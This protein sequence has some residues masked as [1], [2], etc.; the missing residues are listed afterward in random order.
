MQTPATESTHF[1]PVMELLISRDPAELLRFVGCSV[2][3][4]QYRV[5]TDIFNLSGKQPVSRIDS[6][7][8]Q[9][10]PGYRKFLCMV[11]Q[12]TL[13]ILSG[14]I[15]SLLMANYCQ[16]KHGESVSVRRVRQLRNQIRNEARQQVAEHAAATQIHKQKRLKEETH[17]FI[18]G[19]SL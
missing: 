11:V 18:T 7:D 14:L 8:I 2:A 13:Q 15:T 16:E 17:N 3:G 19:H 5:A 9:M 12:G 4:R 10:P 6:I 1:D